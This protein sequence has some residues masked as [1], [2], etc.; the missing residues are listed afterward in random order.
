MNISIAVRLPLA[1]S[2]SKEGRERKRGRKNKNNLSM[3]RSFGMFVVAAVACVTV[4]YGN[5][6]GDVSGGASRK[7]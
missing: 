7:G 2:V 3:Q 6:T 5:H 4:G 1:V